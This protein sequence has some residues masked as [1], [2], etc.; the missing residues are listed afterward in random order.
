MSLFTTRSRHGGGEMR[1]PCFMEDWCNA[2]GCQARL[3]TSIA[4]AAARVNIVSMVARGKKGRRAALA[5]VTCFVL[6]QTALGNSFVNQANPYCRICQSVFNNMASGYKGD[7]CYNTPLNAAGDCQNVVKSMQ[8]SKDVQ[9]LLKKGCMDN[10]GTPAQSRLASKCPPVVACNIIEASSGAPMCGVKLRGWGDFVKGEAKDRPIRSSL[11]DTWADGHVLGP[12][13]SVEVNNFMA[14]GPGSAIVGGNRNC[15]MCIDL[16]NSMQPKMAGAKA[17][18]Q[19]NKLR[20]RLFSAV[21]DSPHCSDQ[22]NSLKAKCEDFIQFFEHNVDVKKLF[23]FGC[24]DKTTTDP[25]EMEPGKCSGEVACN[26]IQ[27]SNGGPMCGQMLGQIGHIAGHPKGAK[28][29]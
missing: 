19:E 5:T 16:F 29:S 4:L 12:G 23:A 24:I 11:K 22:P 2:R 7:L 1:C 21:N 10:T 28:W 26:T 14:P 9:L 15:D 18:K 13:G 3:H 27:D 25:T 17:G 20:R 6:I 8:N